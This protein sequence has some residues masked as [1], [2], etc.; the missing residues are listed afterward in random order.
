[1]ASPQDGPVETRPARTTS[2]AS[3]ASSA[4]RRQRS[5]RLTVAAGLLVLA[6]AVVAASVPTGSFSAVALAAALA[7][8]LGAAA[9]RITHT[10]LAQAR[11]DAARD[12]AEQAQ[13][14]RILTER[15]ALEGA[16]FAEA[17]TLK[18]E[19]R[20]TALRQLEGEL[21]EAQRSVADVRRRLGA[22]ARR[23]EQAEARASRS[24]A[25]L[26]ALEV[27]AERQLEAEAARGA[28]R[29][30]ALEAELHAVRTERDTVRAE[31]Q[32]WQAA[33]A[34]PARKHA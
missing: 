30:A 1:M 24:L 28:E 31:L 12:R 4:R 21:G 29:V 16:A 26:Q 23:A 11:R 10:E 6:A 2:S 34:E 9:T 7:V 32:A 19:E 5:T 14:Y 8:L 22:E 20:E 27:E 3:S 17:M 25:D 33:A 13:D 18:V 15:R